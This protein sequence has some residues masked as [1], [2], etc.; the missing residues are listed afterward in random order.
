MET[1]IET[2]VEFNCGVR[3]FPEGSHAQ[4]E[5]Y[6]LRG[7][8][9]PDDAWAYRFYTLERKITQD[10]GETFEKTSDRQKLTGWHY[11]NATVFTIDGI[12]GD[13]HQILRA[14]MRC[15]NWEHV[16]QCRFGNWQPFEDDDKVVTLEL[17]T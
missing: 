17:A 4:T 14:N 13:E 7:V 2:Y 8:V 1:K 6:D 9:I 3:F 12:L 10:S 11:I 5:G 15:N 16:V